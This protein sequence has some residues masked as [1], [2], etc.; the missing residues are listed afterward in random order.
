MIEVKYKNQVRKKDLTGLLEYMRKNDVKEGMVV[1]KDL[2]K[3]EIEGRRIRY[4]PAWRVL[5]GIG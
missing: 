5:I 4:V 2:S 1:T 3:E